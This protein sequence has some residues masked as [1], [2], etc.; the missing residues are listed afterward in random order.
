MKALLILNTLVCAAIAASP[1]RT[2]PSQ[3]HEG[4]ML[5]ETIERSSGTSDGECAVSP[6]TVQIKNYNNGTYGVRGDTAMF[7]NLVYDSQDLSVNDNHAIPSDQKELKPGT[8]IR[9]EPPSYRNP[10]YVRHNKKDIRHSPCASL[11]VTNYIPGTQVFYVEHKCHHIQRNDIPAN[12]VC[13][14]MY[15][16]RYLRYRGK[17]GTL[18]SV[19]VNQRSGCDLRYKRPIYNKHCGFNPDGE[20]MC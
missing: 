8:T 11:K 2:P 9:W 19:F 18:K 16:Y 15:H 20:D 17:D 7:D 4:G 3:G 10:A 13:G 14:Q 6:G 1:R 5:F 12:M